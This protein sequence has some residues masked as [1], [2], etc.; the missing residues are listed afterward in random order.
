MTSIEREQKTVE[1]MIILY[2]SLKHNRKELCTD[3][4][5]LLNYANKKLLKCPF[6][7]DKPACNDCT[8]R[9]YQKAEKEKI[10]EVMRFSGPRMIYHHPFLAVRHLMKRK[11]KSE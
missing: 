10:R 3:C 5:Y 6:G 4:S 7:Q 1:A 9:C 2:C 8:V 11:K